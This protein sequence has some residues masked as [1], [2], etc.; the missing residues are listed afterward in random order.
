MNIKG[1]ALEDLQFDCKLKAMNVNAASDTAVNDG[2]THEWVLNNYM[3]CIRECEQSTKN[4]LD[5]LHRSSEVKAEAV[6]LL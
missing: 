4:L 5:H 6:K 3:V 1:S 2:F